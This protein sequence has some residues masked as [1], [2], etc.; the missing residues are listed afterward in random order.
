MKKTWLLVLTLFFIRTAN[1]Q[2]LLSNGNF[3]YYVNCPASFT[4]GLSEAFPWYPFSSATPDLFNSCAPATFNVPN[5]FAGYQYAASG[6]G[7]AGG[8]AFTDP[9][10]PSSWKE[11]IAT[12]IPAL[13]IGAAYEISMSVNLANSSGWGVDDMGAFFIA[14]GP[15]S[16]LASGPLGNTPQVNFKSYGAITDTQGWVRIT[17]TFIADSAYTT[18]ALGCFSDGPSMTSKVSAGSGGSYCYYYIDSVVLK[19]ASGININYTGNDL[20]AGQSITVPYTLNNVTFGT[21]NTFTAQLSN[22]TGSFASPV[23][24]GSVTST[25]AGSITAT[26]PLTTPAGTGYKLRIKSSNPVDSSASTADIRITPL[27]AVS[28]FTNAPV[29]EGDTLFLKSSATPSTGVAFAWTGP[30]SFADVAANTFLAPISASQAGKYVITTQHNACITKDTVTVQV[31]PM[32]NVTGGSNTP[33]CPGTTM[34]LTANSNLA[35][36]TF[37]WSGPNSF[38]STLQ[39][40][41]RTPT[42]YADQGVYTVFVTKNGCTS[43]KDIAVAVQITTAT[44]VATNNGPVCEEYALNLYATCATPGVSYTWLGPD[45]FTST[46]QNPVIN[47]TSMRNDGKYSVIAMV[48]GCYSLPDTTDAVINPKP[49]LGNYASPEDT[50]CAGTIVTFVTV[51]MNGVNNPTF[52]WFKNN[53]AVPGETNLTFISPYATGDTFYCRTYC[54]DDCGHNLTLYSNKVGMTILPVINNVSAVLSSVPEHPTPGQPVTFRATVVSGGYNPQYQ[55]QKNGVDVWSAIYAIW[56]T[57]KLSPY[58][59]VNCIVTTSDPCAN[60]M[61]VSSDT[62]TVNFA[63]GVEELAGSNGFQ[64][65]PNPN[66]GSFKFKIQNLKVKTID[67]VNV[68]GQVVYQAKPEAPQAEYTISMPAQLPAGTYMLRVYDGEQYLR[69]TF[70]VTK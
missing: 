29:C 3:E 32:P 11:L 47:P 68:A 46:V 61:I 14:N 37:A 39:N 44:P 53:V 45:N 15:T 4:T 21:G 51:P 28:T 13:S 35:G 41:V 66:D 34:Q 8:Y 52:Q 36:S 30:N 58:D 69:K 20:C 50:V 17:K 55:W 10:D 40:P 63:T 12:P 6:N 43:Q 56:S 38:T 5:A 9:T 22:A 64:L 49:Y 2:N 23:N 24:I 19:L 59:Q 31:K 18:M 65:Y 67:V 33:V 48:N 54:Q 62:M 1:A 57:D 42:A 26:I 60:T 70:T 27:H 16:Y 7:Y 25:T